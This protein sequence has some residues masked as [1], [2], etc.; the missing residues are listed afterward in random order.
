MVGVLVLQAEGLA[1][2]IHYLGFLFQATLASIVPESQQVAV[3]TSF[4]N[5][6]VGRAVIETVG[7]AV[8]WCLFDLGC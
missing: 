7:F 3:P 1:C 4:L 5:Q 8:F 6:V 2:G